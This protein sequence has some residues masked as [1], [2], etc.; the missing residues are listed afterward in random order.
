MESENIISSFIKW[1]RRSSPVICPGKHISEY[2]LKS[3]FCRAEGNALTFGV[4]RLSVRQNC[5]RGE[6]LKSPILQTCLSQSHK[7]CWG[8]SPDPLQSGI[9]SGHSAG[10]PGPRSSGSVQQHRPP[11]WTCWAST[12]GKDASSCPTTAEGSRGPC[13]KRTLVLYCTA[14]ENSRHMA[15]CLWKL[16]AVLF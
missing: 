12:A 7:T 8:P 4:K 2:L 6:R 11:S 16:S 14:C 15:R 13:G 10:P 3:M 5:C 9:A 1:G